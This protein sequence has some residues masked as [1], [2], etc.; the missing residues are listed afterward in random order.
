MQEFVVNYYLAII[1]TL[2]A[3]LVTASA[4][5]YKAWTFGNKNKKLALDKESLQR[6]ILVH[7]QVFQGIYGEIHDNIC[8]SLSLVK[9]NLYTLEMEQ[10]VNNKLQHAKSLV[11]KAIVDLR[12]LTGSMSSQMAASSGL[13]EAI[14]YEL[15]LISRN[16]QYNIDYNE[17]GNS[18]R[19]NGN[20]ETIVFDVF[21]QYLQNI[22]ARTQTTAVRVSIEYRPRQI[23]ITVSDNIGNQVLIESPVT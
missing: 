12:Q 21:Q 5:L 11:S 19:L 13:N 18:V 4:C 9:L 10:P 8:Q 3:L 16:L 7:E 15:Q 6:N 14:K 17:S 22:M 23:N 2:F 1:I 20:K